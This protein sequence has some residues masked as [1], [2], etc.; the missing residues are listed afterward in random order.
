MRAVLLMVLV[1]ACK[2]EAA[3][4]PAKP[5]E[6][7]THETR[8]DERYI[9]VLPTGGDTDAVVKL[10]R[11]RLAAAHVAGTVE[12]LPP[13]PWTDDRR[14]VEE[15]LHPE[16]KPAD[17]DGMS[18]GMRISIT[19]TG[20][21]VATLRALAPI[22]HDAAANAHG[23]VIDPG[24]GGVFTAT[25]FEKHIPGDPLDVR[26]QIYVHEISGDGEEPWLDTM[27]MHELG[28]PELTIRHVAT[29]DVNQAVK[30]VDAVAQTMLAHPDVKV[31]GT[32]D[33]DLATLP[34]DWYEDQLAHGA[35]GRARFRTSWTKDD[36]GEDEIELSPATGSGTEG[37]E[38]LVVEC[39]G[40]A[41]DIPTPVKAN[42]PE[43]EAAARRA[44]S[45]LSAMRAHF[46][47][48]VPFKERLSIKAPFTSEDGQVEWMW[49]DIVRWTGETL[50]GTLANDPE[51][52][53]T[54]K[55]GS[56]V[57]VPFAK[58][59]DFIRITAEGTQSGGY[60]IEVF[61]KRGLMP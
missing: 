52:V 6:K 23:W 19:A 40:A 11:E 42:D 30:L 57:K 48:G 1:A 15:M 2:K 16:L 27:G 44:R 32:I 54:L 45:E 7:A 14:Q 60:S 17:F 18:T 47:K 26:D 61:K 41:P 39:F 59:A 56:H 29:A 43:L 34:G 8:V 5:A 10:A 13:S 21:P 31:P 46:A 53:T 51:V 24:S 37:L 12:A 35:T 33:I 38:A 55:A 58:V 28:F 50:E 25:T 9:V 49:V 36:D 22:A 20:E 3:P 4:A